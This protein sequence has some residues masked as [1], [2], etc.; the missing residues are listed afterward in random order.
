MWLRARRRIGGTSQG[1]SRGGEGVIKYFTISEFGDR[2]GSQ[3]TITPSSLRYEDQLEVRLPLATLRVVLRNQLLIAGCPHP[4]VDVGWPAAVGDGHIALEA[5]LSTLL[6]KHGSPVC[7]VVVS[8]RVGQ[9]ELDVGVGDRLALFGCQDGP[10]EYIPA[11]D[12]RSHGRPWLV[13]RSEHV[14]LGGFAVGGPTSSN[15]LA[16][17]CLGGWAFLGR[18]CHLGRTG[19]R[20]VA[21]SGQHEDKQSRREHASK[22]STLLPRDHG[23]SFPDGHEL[24][25][26]W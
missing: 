21:A 7:I 11:A 13:E 8:L 1:C 4:N 18:L 19:L 5:V 15:S 23:G 9:P 2:G 25:L 16:L 14:G 6:G 20:D 3:K 26:L 12:T 22:P 10:G 24:C 17:P